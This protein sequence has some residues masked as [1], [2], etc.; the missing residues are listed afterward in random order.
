MLLLSQLPDGGI[1][2]RKFNIQDGGSVVR[3]ARCTQD[4]TEVLEG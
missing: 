2:L 1:P 4:H 3:V